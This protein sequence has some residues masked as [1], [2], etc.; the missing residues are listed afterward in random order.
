LIYTKT[1]SAGIGETTVIIP[2]S[3]LPDG[4]YMLK[5]YASDGLMLTRKLVKTK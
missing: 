2:A 3:Q 5:I 1:E 4:I